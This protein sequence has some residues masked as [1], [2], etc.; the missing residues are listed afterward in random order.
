MKS[1]WSVG[2][3]VSVQPNME[4]IRRVLACAL[5]PI[6]FRSAFISSDPLE[7]ID[8]LFCPRQNTLTLIKD[9]SFHIMV[10]FGA[11]FASRD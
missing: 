2:S 8:F 6:E 9:S 7:L 10:A 3:D 4:D 11:E 1:W 5:D